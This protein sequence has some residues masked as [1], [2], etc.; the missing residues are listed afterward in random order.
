MLVTIADADGVDPDAMLDRLQCQ[1]AGQLRQ[2]T[3]RSRIGGDGRK[4]EVRR[5]GGDIDDRPERLGI[6]ALTAS[7]QCRKAAV[8]LTAG[9]AQSSR[10]MSTSLL[11]MMPALLTDV[12][13]AEA[14]DRPPP[15][16]R[17]RLR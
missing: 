3:L 10:V 14:L 2:R 1:R 5:I 11:M 16:P 7:R 6:I 4:G 13:S 15:A 8:A 9:C 12:E 17:P